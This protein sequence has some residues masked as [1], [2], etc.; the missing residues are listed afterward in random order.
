MRGEVSVYLKKDGKIVK[1]AKASNLVTNAVNEFY[2]LALTGAVD[3]IKR[4]GTNP[5]FDRLFRFSLSGV[6]NTDDE[7]IITPYP[8]EALGGILLFDDT[9]EANVNHVKLRPGDP[10]IVGFANVSTFNSSSDDTKHRGK[11]SSDDSGPISNGYRLVWEWDDTRLTGK[12]IKSLALTNL[13]A[14]ANLG[15]FTAGRKQPNGN[16]WSGF[17]QWSAPLV[18]CEDHGLQHNCS[19]AFY[20]DKI[21]EHLYCAAISATSNPD[22]L[23]ITITQ[24]TLSTNGIINQ[25][26]TVF[27]EDVPCGLASYVIE[28]IGFFNFG[29]D[30]YAYCVY[31]EGLEG[32]SS[33]KYLKLDISDAPNFTI[34]DE[35]LDIPEILSDG[36]VSGRTIMNGYFYGCYTY[37]EDR[38]EYKT[39]RIRLSDGQV[40]YINDIQEGIYTYPL[41]GGYVYVGEGDAYASISG[42]LDGDIIT[43]PCRRTPEGSTTGGET[44]ARLRDLNDDG[45]L[46]TGKYGNGFSAGYN[47]ELFLLPGYLGTIYNLPTPITK[48][49]DNETIVI[50]YDLIME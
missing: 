28:S 21:N 6:T 15:P 19:G 7:N 29:Y 37:G 24:N 25:I 44:N 39:I 41:T 34:T 40:D 5:Y 11:I 23:R 47:Q 8:D 33:I 49:S 31:W 32:S 22:G 45:I 20:Y 9:L 43:W 18:Y 17:F 50:Q 46:V 2:H 27:Q 38:T 4:Y 35:S 42:D 13:R 16:T 36:I 10:H 48:N 26:A 14:G 3:F 1:K 30:G 12:T